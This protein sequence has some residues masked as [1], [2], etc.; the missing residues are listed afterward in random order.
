MGGVAREQVP[1]LEKQCFSMLELHMIKVHDF[2]LMQFYEL[3]RESCQKFRRG[4][5]R[6]C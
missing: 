1:L 5:C 6:V 4:K 3:F 2:I